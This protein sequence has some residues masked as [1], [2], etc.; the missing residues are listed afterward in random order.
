MNERLFSFRNRWFTGSLAGLLALLLV[1]GAIGFLWIPYAQG[2][3]TLSGWWEAVCRAAGAP[4]GEGPAADAGGFVSSQVPL[5]AGMIPADPA[6][7]GHGATLSLRCSMCHGARGMSEA[8]TPNL[9]GQH[10]EAV[11]K[12]LR[13]LQTGHRQSAIMA[14]HVQGLSDRDLRDL[15][16]Y[17]ASLKRVTPPPGLAEQMRAPALVQVGAPMRGIAPCASCHGGSER[18]T[19]APALDGEPEAYLRAQML[20]FANGGRRNDIAGQMRN[21]ARAMTPQEIDA[22]SKYYASR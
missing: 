5:V 15:S 2:G 4:S 16:A 8:D 11:Y 12:Q 17:Y 22:V 10:A 3:R 14:P 7:I 18:K 19:G 21:I 20:A 1:F 6:S 9:A 13:D